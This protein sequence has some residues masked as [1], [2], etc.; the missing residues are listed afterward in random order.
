VWL[1]LAE[2]DDGR[3]ELITTKGNDNPMVQG[4]MPL[5]VC[6]V[7]EHAY[8]L[9]YKNLRRQYIQQWWDVVNW[10]EAERRYAK[11][12]NKFT[13]PLKTS[14]VLIAAGDLWRYAA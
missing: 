14:E 9:Q 10:R 8:Y 12:N 1:T 11:A 7:W 3:L 6:D 5:L 2:E 4:L 13:L